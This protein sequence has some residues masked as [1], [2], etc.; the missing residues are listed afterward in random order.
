MGEGFSSYDNV[1]Y[2]ITPNFLPLPKK[3]GGI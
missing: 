1:D 2:S 3:Y